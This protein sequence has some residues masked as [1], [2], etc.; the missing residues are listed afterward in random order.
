MSGDVTQGRAPRSVDAA[1]RPEAPSA[2]MRGPASAQSEPPTTLTP[3]DMQA[4]LDAGQAQPLSAFVTDYVHYRNH[5]W[6]LAGS[7][8]VRVDDPE[9]DETLH[10]YRRRMSGG[11]FGS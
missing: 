3:E 5:W 10:K 2:G 1:A 9:L 11:L 6:L 8:W 7:T 4:L